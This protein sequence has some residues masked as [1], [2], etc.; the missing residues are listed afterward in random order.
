MVAVSGL[1]TGIPAGCSFRPGESPQT[2]EQ[3]FNHEVAMAQDAWNILSDPAKSDKWAQATAQYNKA[4]YGILQQLRNE[5]RKTGNAVNSGGN[6][7][8]VIV[9]NL[10]SNDRSPRIYDDLVPCSTIDT[11]GIL[12]ERVTAEG[13][14]IP[15]AGHVRRDAKPIVDNVI[16]D[17]G[18]VHT[19]TVIINF[20]RTRTVN[21]KP[22]LRLIPRLRQES[23]HVG[24]NHIRQP[25]A[26]DFSA[27]IVEFVNKTE[28]NRGAFFG[29]LD[30]AK[31][32]SYMGLYF[33]EPYD[34]D[35]IPVI[36]THGLLSCHSTF[37]NLN[38]RLWVDPLIRKHYQFWFYAYPTGVPW[39]Q[40]AYRQRHA[41]NT[42]INML[43][44]PESRQN[45]KAI[46]MVGH[47]MGGLITRLNNST[48][49]WSMISALLDNHDNLQKQTYSQTLASSNKDGVITPLMK[50]TFIFKPFERT[51]RMVFMA[52]PH[53]G[54]FFS[55]SWIGRLGLL[56]TALPEA[57]ADE[58]EKL[59]TLSNDILLF[60]PGKTV[61]E[62]KSIGQLSPKS[63]F[64]KGLQYSFPGRG[65]PVHSIIGDR[66]KGDTP[67]SS[68][69]IVPYWSSHLPWAASETI[70]PSG[71]SVQDDLK[72]AVEM[73]LILREHLKSLGISTKELPLYDSPPILWRENPR[74]YYF[75]KNGFR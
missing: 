66:G 57:F 63:P 32:F 53:R 1:L 25:L 75:Q 36:F 51:K 38:N 61:N 62:L 60:N 6:Y 10:I 56:L 16:M 58:A 40:I 64:I 74:I 20:D 70:V 65:I 26:A 31:G 35:K 50:E 47:S 42:A 22:T 33:T 59:A 71:H 67:E 3:H 43:E 37:A 2:L 46:V 52:T 72:S 4:V 28:Q 14:G 13:M 49:P 30:P 27:P 39:T 45:M 11:S 9:D 54:S 44:V 41:V 19:L 17:N 29:L 34:P 5:G 24:P 68:D 23:I 8:F 48:R 69:G 7:P 12:A 73:R 15:V 21:G 55:E 18:N